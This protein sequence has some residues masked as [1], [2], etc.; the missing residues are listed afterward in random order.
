[1]A[2]TVS[3]VNINF[4]A[5]T[6]G[7]KSGVKEVQQVLGSLGGNVPGV[8]A[9][10]NSFGQL[11]SMAGMAAGAVSGTAVAIAAVAAAV[12][13]ASAIA[14]WGIQLASQAEQTQAS[15]EVMLGSASKATSM[16]SDLREL[17]AA[18]PLQINGLTDN[19][20]MLLGFGVAGE[21]VLPTLRM[22]GDVSGGDAEK[23]TRLSLAFGQISAAGRLM[24]QDLLQL[25][26]AGFNPLQEISKNTGRSMSDLKKDMEAGLISF[27]M[28]KSAFESATGEGGRFNGM[29][30]KMAE[31]F[32]GKWGKLQ[33]AIGA[34]GR[35]IGEALLPAAKIVL[36]ALMDVADAVGE[37]VTA[38][39]PAIEQYGILFA[40]TFAEFAVILVDVLKQAAAFS[41]WLIET[42][43]WLGFLKK[44]ATAVKPEVEDTTEAIK[45]VT[46][47]TK[48]AEEAMK[49]LMTAGESLTKSM[50]LPDEIYADTITELKSLAAAGAITEET[51]G[52][53]FRK[54]A[55]EL[56]KAAVKA[57]A[58]FKPLNAGAVTRNSATG[59]SAVIDGQNAQKQLQSLVQKQLDEDRKHTRQNEEMLA[60]YKQ[61]V[62]VK[63]VSL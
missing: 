21:D 44:T 18:T 23:M 16:I 26:N 52:R 42:A 14:A 47:E 58:A 62:T 27:D 38:N 32:G 61:A 29:M 22:L 4:G 54:A 12:T 40:S 59:F 51:F 10:S 24:G 31:T 45:Q 39:L 15:I 5:N 41:G 63:Q 43:Q 2:A 46:E 11:G 36:S 8:G 56:D 9:V 60:A 57:D 55:E 19:T 25:I 7:L 3:N 35:T 13:G 34:I 28:V 30:D 49:K 6:S 17:A 37:L 20:K 48:A 53:A 33:E 50:R 1:M